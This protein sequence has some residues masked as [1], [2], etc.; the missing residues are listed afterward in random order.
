M[1]ELKKPLSIGQH[2]I[3]LSASIGIS[4]YPND[5]DTVEDILVSAD[6][7]MY[8]SKKIGKNSFTFFENSMREYT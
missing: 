4:V 1:T 3:F 5:G 2:K 8:H 6:L 7:S